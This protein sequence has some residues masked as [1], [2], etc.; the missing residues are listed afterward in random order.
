MVAL[1]AEPAGV[2]QGDRR[3]NQALVVAAAAMFVVSFVTTA[4][5]IAVPVLEQDFPDASLTTTSWVVSAFNVTQVNIL[6]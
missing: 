2:G 1:D 5:N 3:A 6:G 4:S